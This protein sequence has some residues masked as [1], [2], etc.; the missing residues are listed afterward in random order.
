MY[1]T[2]I[3]INRRRREAG[4]LLGSRQAMHAAVESLFPP[5][6]ETTGPKRNLWRLD[7][8]GNSAWLYVVSEERPDA[9]SIV[10]NAGWP[11]ADQKTWESADYVRVLTKVSDGSRFRFK[12]AVNPI[13]N[14]PP[15]PAGGRGKKVPI[16]GERAQLE[17]FTK[18]LEKAGAAIVTNELGGTS[19]KI[20][21]SGEDTFNRK[22]ASI[23]LTK[24]TITGV[25]EVTDTET[26]RKALTTGIGTG[27]AYGLG[28]LTIAAA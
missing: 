10:E 6:L 24:A 13:R 3:A 26:F 27:K 8:Q 2:R 22:G 20:V 21:E 11:D 23:T 17:W 15:E 25:L 28:L 18:T 5:S 9:T 4:K 16:K 19:A 14:L 1:I 12:I 7:A